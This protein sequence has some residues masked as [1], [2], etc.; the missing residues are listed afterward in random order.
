[1]KRLQF[2]QARQ[3]ISKPATLAAHVILGESAGKGKNE[4]VKAKI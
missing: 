1:M 2:N 4:C 3:F